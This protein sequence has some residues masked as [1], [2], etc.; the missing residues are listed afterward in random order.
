MGLA[1]GM[2]WET[3]NEVVAFE[4]GTWIQ[5]WAQWEDDENAGQYLQMTCNVK[6]DA[7]KEV[8]LPANV[9][10]R[11]LGGTSIDHLTVTTGGPQ[12]IGTLSNA[13]GNDIQGQGWQLC[14]AD[15][16]NEDYRECYKN[17]QNT[18]STMQRCGAVL[19]IY[20]EI[21]G[22][23]LTEGEYAKMKAKNFKVTT[24]LRMWFPDDLSTAAIN[25]PAGTTEYQLMDWDSSSTLVAS[26]VT[27]LAS[28][29]LF[30]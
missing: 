4:D 6:F 7:S 16:D 27:L 29:A 1:F 14:N 26:A 22:K 18:Y 3:Y 19:P 20:G 10:I 17:V 2:I 15:E 23:D 30:Q 5:N 24:G 12:D 21:N 25:A 28:I 11:A 8:S 9:L 13:W